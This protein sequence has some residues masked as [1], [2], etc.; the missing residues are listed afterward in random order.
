MNKDEMLK[1]SW[2]DLALRALALIGLVAILVLGA[3]GIIQ[4][5]F[6]LP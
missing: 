3:W 2:V 5:A 1:R 6:G 4:L